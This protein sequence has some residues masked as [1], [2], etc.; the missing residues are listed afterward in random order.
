MI[1]YHQRRTDSRADM[2][3][4][5]GIR[6]RLLEQAGLH[7]DRPCGGQ[8]RCGKCRVL[9]HGALS[10]AAPEERKAPDGGGAGRRDASG[11]HDADLRPR[12]GH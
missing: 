1:L 4:R 11:L 2:G 8:G 9:A 12:R 10:P 7:P 5:T 3:R 6:V